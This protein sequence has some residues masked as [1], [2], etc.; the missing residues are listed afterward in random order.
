MFPKNLWLFNFLCLVSSVCHAGDC[1]GTKESEKITETQSRYLHVVPGSRVVITW[2]WCVAIN[3]SI[4]GVVIYRVT[5]VNSRVVT[6]QV[7]LSMDLLKKIYYLKDNSRHELSSIVNQTSFQEIAV[8][9]IHNV[10]KVDSGEYSLHVR[11]LGY[12]D[13]HNEIKIIVIT[14]DPTNGIP[15]TA[16]GKHTTK[17]VSTNDRKEDLQSSVRKD[18]AKG[19][20]IVPMVIVIFAVLLV[21][22]AVLAVLLKLRMSGGQACRGCFRSNERRFNGVSDD[23]SYATLVKA[24]F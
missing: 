2:K 5:R 6:N 9:I 13:L 4:T 11:R 22:L 24:E 10:S 20:G 17:L 12:S 18:K 1:N 23:P 15:S 19:I 8:F 14:G 7:V 3:S 21:C 16:F